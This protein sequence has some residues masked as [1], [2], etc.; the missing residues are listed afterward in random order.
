MEAICQRMWLNRVRRRQILFAEGN[1]STHLYAI[2]E[3]KIKLVNV[4]AG[5]REHVMAVLESGDLF[6]F[7]AIFD[8]AYATDAEALTDGELCLAAGDELRE[9]ISRVPTMAIDFARYLHHQLCQAG[10]RQRYLSASGARAKLA[11]YLLHQLPEDGEGEGFVVPNDLTLRDLG[12]ALG[13]APETVCRTFSTL[14]AT[15][16][17][18]THPAGIR[19]RDVTTLRRLSES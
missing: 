5:G 11:G 6:G 12:G 18:E 3:G 8:S 4:D 2:R 1:R 7:E 16:V 19:V 14:R 13:L 10:A 9:L 15:E 17:I